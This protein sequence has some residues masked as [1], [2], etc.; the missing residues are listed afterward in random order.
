MLQGMR[1]PKEQRDYWAGRRR[2]HCT[3]GFPGERLEPR[4]EEEGG[5][6]SRSWSR[7]GGWQLGVRRGVEQ[8]P[9]S[10]GSGVGG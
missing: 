2:S 3:E 7:E 9:S 4:R 8:G 5:Q 10:E 1:G 6:D